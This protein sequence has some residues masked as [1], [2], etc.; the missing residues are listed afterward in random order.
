MELNEFRAEMLNDV[1][2]R[3][4]AE[5]G[6]SDWAFGSVAVA[7]LEEANEVAD[8][9]ACHYRSPSGQM[10]IDGYSFDAADD[11][12]R[13][14]IIHRAAGDQ[15]ETLTQS[16]AKPIF[17]RLL[18]FLEAGINGRFKRHIDDN[19]P[20][21][22]FAETLFSRRADVSR[23]RAYLLTDCVLSALVKDWPEGNIEGIPTEFHIW[24]IGRFY[25]AH[26]STSGLDEVV[27]D[28]TDL[29]PGGLPALAAA[30]PG[31]PYVAYLCVV[32]ASL[33]AQIY[34]QHG[35]RLLEGN[36]RAFLTAKGKV[37]RGIRRTLLEQP[38]MFFAYNN[39][40]SAVASDVVVN[41]AA[42]GTRLLSAT[43]L[44][45][46]NGGQTTA[47]I[48][49]VQRV[50]KASRLEETF[51]PMKLAVVSGERSAPMIADISRFANSQN[52]VSDADFFSNHP[53][54]QRMEQISR[55]LLAPAHSGMQ[56]ETHWYYERARGQY[57]NEF[58]KL[59]PGQGERM[60]LVIPKAQIITK[61]D[62]ARYELSWAGRPNIVSQG[63]QSVFLEFA[64]RIGAAWS[65]DPDAF[66]EEYFRDVVARTIVFR[67]TEKLVT[68]QP[69]YVVGY[70]S[71]I[72]SYTIAKVAQDMMA[73]A[74]RAF[75]FSRIWKRQGIYSELGEQLVATAEIVYSRL[76]TLPPTQ[77]NITQWAKRQSCWEEIKK[78]P[79]LLTGSFRNTLIHEMEVRGGNRAA[80]ALQQLD[81]GIDCQATMLALGVGYWLALAKWSEER[82]A[83]AASDQRALRMAAGLVVGLPSDK[84]S[85]RLLELKK[86]FE[87]DG[88]I[89]S[90]VSG[91]D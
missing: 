42:S 6:F 76:N 13:V 90:V 78:L 7:R 57:L 4:A 77:Q 37:N 20:A 72:V 46:V 19:H 40:I 69:W 80:K 74:E 66:H 63:A 34:D 8:F 65:S 48:A 51:V 41:D 54:H 22:D 82:G 59:T 3:L 9:E 64:A 49:S 85:K 53:F 75:D 55:R 70:R 62:L 30:T 28:F 27:I 89:Y 58:A 21:R 15:L 10:R 29:V 79:L 60:K 2:V 86:R 5:G 52:K 39:G 56:H 18:A 38:E 23:I 71:I 67:A 14:F 50:D 16:E 11:S 47:S 32:P 87:D 24:D 88:F 17:R 68:S 45:I 33:L 36:V 26:I 81:T 43:D 84:Q 61:T 31:S 44:Q 73:C 1:Q 91:A 35:S 83:L 25:R 12:L